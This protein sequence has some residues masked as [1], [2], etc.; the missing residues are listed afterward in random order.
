MAKSNAGHDLSGL[1]RFA[2]RAPWDERLDEI[3]A[4]HLDPVC[5]ATGLDREAMFDAVG[6]HWEGTVWGCAFED[7]LA[8]DDE[9]EG[10]N[11]VDD[12][13]KRRGWNEKG[14][15]KAYTAVMPELVNSD[16]EGVV[17]HRI[18][19]PLASR[20]QCLATGRRAP[21]PVP[22][23]GGRRSQSGSSIWRMVRRNL[24]QRTIPWRHSILPGCGR[25]LASGI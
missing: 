9:E 14:P 19:F 1:I 18:V 10:S 25:N 17:F 6:H 12:Y 22:R 16:G 15:N 4:L 24:A 13:L 5:E 7:L 11:L 21:W 2:G 3:L 20:F 8:R 23:R